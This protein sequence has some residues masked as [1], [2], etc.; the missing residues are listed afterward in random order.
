M[1]A[2][3]AVLAMAA[4][5]C[6]SSSPSTSGQSGTSGAGTSSTSAAPSAGGSSA[7]T[8]ASS[9]TTAGGGSAQPAAGK[10][11]GSGKFLACMVTDTGGIND[12]SFNASAYLGLQDASKS[13]SDISYTYLQSNST[14]D[15]VPNIN[16]LIQKKCKIIVTVGYDM[17]D[18][19]LAAAKKN[20]SVKFTIV[21]NTYPSEPKN[22]LAL[23]YDTNE[24]AFLGGYLAAA[25]SK[26]DKVGTFGGQ[27][28]PTVTIYMDGWVAGVR[29]Y[30]KVN[31]AHVVALGWTPK[32]PRPKNSFEGT[33][34]FTNN[35]TS[36]SLGEQDAQALMAQGADVV[37]PVAGAV[38]LGSAAAVK[39]KGAGYMMEW[40]DVDGCVSAP[41]YCSLFITSVTKGIVPSVEQAVTS[42]AKGTFK[43]GQYNGTLANNGVA[44]SPFHD[45]AGKVPAKVQTE[46]K[47]LKAGIISGKISTDPNSY[48]AS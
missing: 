12:R 11:K 21:D 45:Y 9:G 38:G 29:Y 26:T 28:I 6:G 43:G 37:F 31:N 48:P 25:M 10:V 8:A 24:D 20:P 5:A 39:Q 36:S 7:T 33:G 47:T 1:A 22:L 19:T 3:V 16:A 44:L 14:S 46:L 18:A 42:A 2:G 32:D 23:S 35:F 13:D 34:T 27:D 41:Q 30:D 40:V 15:Y 4:A 17:A